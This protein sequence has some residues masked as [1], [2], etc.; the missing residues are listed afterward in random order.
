MTAYYNEIDPAAAHVLRALISDGVIAPGDVD[1]RSITAVNPDDLKGYNQCHFFAGGGLW[2]VAAR[3]AG[4]PDDKP[5]WTGSCPCQ[6]LSVAGLGK[7]ADDERHLWPAFYRLISECAPPI[8]F[9]EQVASMLG[10]EWFAGV[11]SDLEGLGYAC[12]AADLCAAGVGAPHIRQRLYWVGVARGDADR[13][14]QFQHGGA[15]AVQAQQPSTERAGGDACALD[16]PNSPREP[17]PQGDVS[18]QRGWAVNAS[19]GDMADTDCGG[20]GGRPETSQWVEERGTVVQRSSC[21]NGSFWSDHEWLTGADGKARRAK[22]G[23]RLLVDAG[24]CI[25]RVSQLRI[26][27]NAIV[28]P[29]AAEFVAATLEALQ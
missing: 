13:A 19:Q 23:V 20:C 28:A 9:G 8:V 4:W 15:F 21:R 11:R 14:G 27:G 5:I 6:S 1:D 2:S 18:E 24:Q 12:G 26:A 10:R 22:P 7:G 16:N 25:G 3:I 29:L 17:Q